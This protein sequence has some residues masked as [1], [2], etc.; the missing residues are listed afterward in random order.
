ML[1]KLLA[2]H[3]GTHT[4][5]YTWQGG[6][7]S[8][9]HIFNADAEGLAEFAA[10]LKKHAGPSLYFLVDIVAEDFRLDTIPHLSGRSR[11]ALIGRKLEQ[12]FRNETHRHAAI[13]GRMTEGR[14]DDRLLLSALTNNESLNPWI[15]AVLECKIPLAGIYSV[16]LLSQEIIPELGLGEM[17]H[18]LLLTRQNRAGLR[19][20]YFQNGRLKFSRLVIIDG[21]GT[22]SLIQAINE[23]S[24][25][26]QQ[27]LNNQRL[28]PR[29]QRLE[30]HLLCRDDE[31]SAL[32]DGCANAPLRHQFV[33]HELSSVAAALKLRYL[34]SAN[35]ATL[36]LQFLARH[37]VKNHYASVSETRY[38][39]L[40]RVA[41]AMRSSGIALVILGV[42]SASY[43]ITNGQ[44]LAM[45]ADQTRIQAERLDAQTQAMREALP[46]LPAEPDVL[47]GTV[48]LAKRLTAHP[49]TPEILMT[50]ISR[51]LEE[52]PQIRLQ[53]FKWAQ[54]T[55]PNLDI[56]T[57]A[58]V[59]TAE[60]STPDSGS[61]RLEM[62]LVEGEVSPFINYRDALAVVEQLIS[63]L[64]NVP[65]LQVTP[66]VLPIETDPQSQLKGRLTE[67]AQP[68]AANFSLKLTYRMAGS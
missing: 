36:F 3:T 18:L 22:D 37:D 48:E 11:S 29:D 57:K 47:K 46:P 40:N 14:R 9:G 7:L 42:L 61:E 13:Q 44:N 45:Q 31:C 67:D 43:N 39:R 30:I 64:K 5:V 33:P 2:Y 24:A 12:M 10:Y 20:S 50:L 38:W 60:D 21:N 6:A 51:A 66:I 32:L 23:E 52:L 59:P 34:P 26:T 27:Y 65:G 62:A 49:R 54:T 25:K 55:N 68:H 15:D 28:L 58:P 53:H 63:K 4:E 19:Q 8:G 56:G 1:S 41:F 17:P 16:P 35:V